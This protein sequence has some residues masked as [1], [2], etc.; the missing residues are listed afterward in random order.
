[1]GDLTFVEL[2]DEVR[3]ALGG[4]TDLDSRLGRSINLAQQRLAR[5]HDFY[6]MQIISTHQIMNNNLDNDRFL[7]LPTLREVYSLVLLH[8]AESRKLV[9]RTTQWLDRIISMPEYWARQIPTDYVVWGTYIEM[10]ALPLDTYTLR[11]RW[12]QWPLALSADT[13]LSQFLHKDELLIE[14]A[15]VYLYNSLGKESDAS[16]HETR[17]KTLMSEALEMDRTHPDLNIL[18]GLS[19]VQAQG[20]TNNPTPWLNPFNT[21]GN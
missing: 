2:K 15:L 9:N 12:T 18:P 21:T 7:Q 10:Y 4:R 6:E 11:M 13:D 8:G 20:N 5:M 19:D 17:V 3:S 1:M 16:K 14:L